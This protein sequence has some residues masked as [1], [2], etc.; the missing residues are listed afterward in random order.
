MHLQWHYVFFIRI[1][2]IRITRLKIALKLRI[3]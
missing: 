1:F 2:F 3:S